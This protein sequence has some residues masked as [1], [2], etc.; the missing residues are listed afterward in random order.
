MSKYYYVPVTSRHIKFDNLSL[1]DVTATID[2]NLK[3]RELDRVDILEKDDSYF[4][5]ADKKQILSQYNAETSL[6]YKSNCIPKKLI[7]IKNE[8]GLRELLTGNKLEV[9]DNY[10]HC[11]EIDVTVSD[12]I[13]ESTNYFS[14]SYNYFFLYNYRKA[15]SDKTKIKK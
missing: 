4:L 10:L 14:E 13:L 1:L 5:P 15:K 7:L 6:C 2:S 11:F 3:K 9:I 12:Y 8:R